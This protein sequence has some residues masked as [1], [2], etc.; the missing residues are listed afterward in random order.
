MWL[1]PSQ[2]RLVHQ[3]SLLLVCLNAWLYVWLSIK[4]ECAIKFEK[5]IILLSEILEALLFQGV[6][7]TIL[8]L[9]AIQ[10]ENNYQLYLFYF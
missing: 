8:L 7:L 3:F 4:N 6:P 10:I 5:K 9:S 2:F 1:V